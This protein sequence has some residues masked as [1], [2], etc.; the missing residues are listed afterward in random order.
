MAVSRSPDKHA[1]LILNLGVQEPRYQYRGRFVRIG[2]KSANDDAL[3]DLG[4]DARNKGLRAAT[5]ELR[6]RYD[7]SPDL[8]H[9]ITYPIAA[10][11]LSYVRRE[12]GTL[13]ARVV[14]V[15]TNFSAATTAD[16][17]TNDN[18]E[19][20]A[21]LLQIW[22][23]A[24]KNIPSDIVM[25]GNDPHL[26]QNADPQI[27]NAPEFKAL[28]QWDRVYAC[29][30]PGLPIVNLAIFRYGMRYAGEKFVPFQIQEADQADLEEG[31]ASGAGVKAPMAVIS[32][33]S[34]KDFVLRALERYD[35]PAALAAAK[36]IIVTPRERGIELIEEAIACWNMD[37]HEKAL[38]NLLIRLWASTHVIDAWVE[39]GDYS[40]AAWRAGDVLKKVS[41]IAAFKLFGD[42]SLAACQ[43]RIPLKS[44]P[45]ALSPYLDL[46]PRDASVKPGVAAS[47]AM[48]G[49]SEDGSPLGRF[50]GR[51][52]DRGKQLQGRRNSFVHYFQPVDARRFRNK[53]CD[54][55]SCA[56]DK[57][58]TALRSYIEEL[59]GLAGLTPPAAMIGFQTFAQRNAEIR[60]ELKV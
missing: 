24:R 18:T 4:V 34:N 48:K 6:I 39:T 21:E 47:G 9:R 5:L 43:N 52:R 8:L 37:F 29:L 55:L 32:D 14:I 20:S 7:Q 31:K 35:Y 19:F 23:R 30:S 10:S 11:S 53:I 59:L 17:P 56:P 13:P 33:D 41:E 49:A 50:C 54:S 25:L 45:P 12:F 36:R 3:R 44:I 27:R 16:D 40:L 1:C 22:L 2:G 46:D 42:A 38:D 51:V 57:F 58:G 28:D 60:K 26:F 15:A